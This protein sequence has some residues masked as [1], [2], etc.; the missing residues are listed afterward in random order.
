MEEG[1]TMQ[2]GIGASTT[3]ILALTIAA[4]CAASCSRPPVRPPPP[5][6]PPA[7]ALV[8]TE[9]RIS[10][11][12]SA[13]VELHAWL[14]SAARTGEELE[15]E[16]EPARRTY[17]RSLQDDDEDALLDRTTHALSSCANDRCSS[18]ALAAEGFGHSYDRALPVFVARSWLSRAS[19]AWTGIEAS[20]AAL[21]ATGPAAEAIFA[22]AASDLGMGWPDSPVIVDV[23]SEA[24]PLGRAALLP[25]ALATRGSCFMRARTAERGDP[26]L[27]HA[28]VLDCVLVHALHAPRDEPPGAGALH[29]ALVREL[30]SH[31][32]E[33]AWSL[34]VIHEVAAVVTGWEP[35]HRSVYRRSAEAVEPSMLEWLAKQWRGA[36]SEPFDAFAPRYAARWRE[37]HLKD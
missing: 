18:A 21:G 8:V 19:V 24:P 32:G 11:R 27:D 14:A 36:R 33:R 9:G 13:W 34:L 26:Q 25:A 12:A 37:A 29:A 10:L 35:K 23:V 1:H 15:G 22:R 17:A 16:L 3:R 4:F 5:R 7:R 30:G 2:H 31:D 28:R 20:H 6:D